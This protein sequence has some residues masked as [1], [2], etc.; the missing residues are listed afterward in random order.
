[1]KKLQNLEMKL[2][3]RTP[4]LITLGITLIIGIG[5]FTMQNNF[6]TNQK[7][8]IVDVKPQIVDST[9]NSSSTTGKGQIYLMGGVTTNGVFLNN[10]VS[11]SDGITWNQILPNAPWSR[12][13]GHSTVFFNGKIFLA[14]GSSNTGNCF[15]DVW[16]SPDGITWSQNTAN[17]AWSP[18]QGTALVVLNNKLWVY[19]GIECSGNMVNDVWSS[20]DGITWTQVNSSAP[21]GS[22][23]WFGYTVF[24]NKLWLI[25]GWPNNNNP[26]DVWSSPDGITWTLVN[27]AAP[28]FSRAYFKAFTFDNKLWITG[29][30][31]IVVNGNYLG[32]V[33]SSPDGITWTQATNNGPSLNRAAFDTFVFNNKMW[34]AGG[35]MSGALNDVWSSLNGVSW[36]QATN[37][38]T[39]GGVG[40][41]SI[42]VTSSTG[43]PSQQPTVT[44]ISASPFTAVN[45][46][47]TGKVNPNGTQT[48]GYFKYGKT[49]AMTSTTSGTS[50][51]VGTAAVGF[52]KYISGLVPNTLYYYQACATYTPG[53]ICGAT[54]TFTTL[55]SVPDL[56][57]I[58][59]TFDQ[60][61]T[62]Q[63][64][65]AARV[66]YTFT[67]KN[68]LN[69]PTVLPVGTKFTLYYKPGT[70]Y[71]P[72]GETAVINTPTP[73]AALATLTFTNSTY[74]SPN[75]R[76]T[77]G[78]FPA[79]ISADT[80]NLVIETNELNNDL[81]QNLVIVP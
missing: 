76:A 3:V 40:T 73:L 21:W 20:P 13:Q 27:P 22:R 65:T 44:T 58:S 74:L 9:T 49:T 25:A 52:S 62:Q 80:T 81:V 5:Y 11:S 14:G 47:L 32:D 50:M 63:S 37:N 28:W 64:V 19:G 69:A 78:T 60:T 4:L 53:P 66:R 36:T 77:L 30:T 72:I 51:G 54:R 7:A 2:A 67:L 68:D 46:T 17:A 79:K 45:A 26:S 55:N 41:H 33:W 15:N 8:T 75:A 43:V 38:L 12:R 61:T 59:L 31:S 29:G 1:M 70:T 10:V 16:S 34:L 42:V 57:I 6:P 56:K 71:I 18:R 24:Q 23:R 48:V 39:N 35:L